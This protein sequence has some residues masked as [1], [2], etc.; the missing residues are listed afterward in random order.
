[1]SIPSLPTVVDGKF[2]SSAITYTDYKSPFRISTVQVPADV[3]PNEVLIKTQAASINPV[4]LI[5]KILSPT[6][7]F[8]ETPTKRAGGDFA[9]IVVKA[10]AD[11]GYQPGDRV[12]GDQLDR[13][14]LTGSL[15]E[16]LLLDPS[17]VFTFDKI[18][19]GLTFAEAAGIPLAGNTA[20]GALKAHEK[21][22]KGGH[23]LILGAGTSVGHYAAQL[24]KYHFEVKSIVGTASSGSFDRVRKYGVDKLIDYTKGPTHEINEILEAVKENG[25]FDL[26][27]DTVR[28]PILFGYLDTVLKPDSEGGVFLQIKGSKTLN[29]KSGHYLDV[30]PQWQF[31]LETLKEGWGLSKFKFVGFTK[32]Q[33]RDFLAIVKGLLEKKE[34]TVDIDSKYDFKDFQAAFD[35]VASVKSKG[36]V[37]IEFPSD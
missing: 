16:Y 4:D 7:W 31:Y 33:N 24:T 18:P 5:R 37:I 15:S 6:S 19:E 13:S 26:V 9:G 27:I 2:K 23:V 25:K 32:Y 12:Y 3:G 21:P 35:R 22:L 8:Y 28:D 20:Y 1:M 34:F 30:L 11:T 10:G 17:K 36:K 14:G 29:Y